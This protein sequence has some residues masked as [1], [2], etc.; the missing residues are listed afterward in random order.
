MPD[1]SDTER[2][3]PDLSDTVLSVSDKLPDV[4]CC[5]W[6]CCGLCVVRFSKTFSYFLLDVAILEIF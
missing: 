5:W 6:V 1:L 2:T 4:L 3:V